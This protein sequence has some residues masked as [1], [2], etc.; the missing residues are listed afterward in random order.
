MPGRSSRRARAPQGMRTYR[1]SRMQAATMLAVTFKR[2]ARF[3][4]AAWWKQATAE[5]EG[6]RGSYP[7]VL[8]LTPETERRLRAWCAAVPARGLSAPQGWVAFNVDF[9]SESQA[10][11]VALGLGSGVCVLSPE[12]LRKLVNR[13]AQATALRYADPEQP[14]Q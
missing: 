11:F 4:L 9:E 12:R 8:A 13:E 2:P 7:A 5:L 10:T 3:N 1:I 6:R 14:A